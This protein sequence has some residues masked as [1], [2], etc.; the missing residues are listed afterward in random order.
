MAYIDFP[1]GLEGQKKRKAFFLSEDGLELI[2]GWRRQ[3]VPLTEIAEKYIGISKTAFW[4]WYRGSEELRK[5]CAVSQDICNST[6]EKSLYQRAMGYDYYEEVHE[7]I[8]GNMTLVK[9]YK[10]HV[11]ADVKAILSWLYNRMPGR[12]R[13]IQEPLE[14]TQYTE[15]IKNVLVAMKEVAETG[16]DKEIETKEQPE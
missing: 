9:K 11:P 4:G 13:A 16:E 15:T 3:G 12:W 14:S 10:K 2:S 1:D 6:V 7:L 8:E 5:A